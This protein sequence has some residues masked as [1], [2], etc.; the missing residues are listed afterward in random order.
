MKSCFTLLTLLFILGSVRAQGIC[1]PAGNIIIYSNYDGGN[2][3]INIDENVP[4]IKIGLCSYEAL[5]VTIT[6]TYAGNVTAVQYAGYNSGGT[7]DIT[8]VA[9]AII[10]ILNYPP[11]TMYDPDGYPYMICAYECDTAYVPGGCNTVDQ[12][13]DYFINEFDGSIRYSYMQYGVWSGS[14]LMSEGGNCCVDAACSIAIDGGQDQTIC[15]GDSVQMTPTGALTYSWFPVTGLSDAGVAAPYASP[16][17]TTT[18]I[19]TGTDAGGCVGVDSIT[20]FVNPLPIPDITITGTTFTASGGTS[21][22]WY[23]DGTLIPGATDA[24]YTVTESGAYSCEVTS[25]AGCSAM[26]AEYEI[27][28]NGIHD[29][30]PFVYQIYPN[31]ASDRLHVHLQNASAINS[32][33]LINNAGQKVGNYHPRSL[34]DIDLPVQSL[35]NGI[36]TILL[37]GDNNITTSTFIV[38]H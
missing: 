16:E 18:Y 23:Q 19:V 14:Y 25:A 36:Y 22:Q 38:N 26:S 31:P 4:D 2:I 11:V 6:G 10:E 8:G 27:E 3:I 21:Y 15:L 33:L 28:L 5:H 35:A 37:I 9:A 24:T 34:S 29:S 12:A 20:V 13:T 30:A 32:I 1:N 17:V 7:T